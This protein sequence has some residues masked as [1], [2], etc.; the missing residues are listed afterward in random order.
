MVG[1]SPLLDQLGPNILGEPEVG[2]VIAV[3]VAELAA[4]DLERELASP[5]EPRVDSGP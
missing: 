2:G 5:T 1:D 4:A 3:K